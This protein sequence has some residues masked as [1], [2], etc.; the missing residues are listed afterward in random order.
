[1]RLPTSKRV[2]SSLGRSTTN[3]PS[4]P[5][6]LPTRPTATQPGAGSPVGN[7]KDDA[8][9]APSRARADERPERAGD[10]S[11]LADHLPHLIR[12]NTKLED[13]GSVLFP[14]GHRDLLGLVDQA[15]G[16]V[17]EEL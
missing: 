4:M 15:F 8:V 5:C 10:A 9:A 12:G 2:G 17:L 14:S 13:D 7:L 11:A 1:M 3:D 6:A 16:Q